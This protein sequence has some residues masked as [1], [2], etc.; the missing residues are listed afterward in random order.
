MEL[1]EKLQDLQKQCRTVPNLREATD[2][3][4]SIEVRVKYAKKDQTKVVS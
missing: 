3:I 4:C 2:E 1:R